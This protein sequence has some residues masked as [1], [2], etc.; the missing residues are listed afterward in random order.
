MSRKTVFF[1]PMHVKSTIFS[2][3][4]EILVHIYRMLSYH[5]R[6]W[7]KKW[8]ERGQKMLE[9]QKYSAGGKQLEMSAYVEKRKDKDERRM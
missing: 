2:E 6:R 1:Y 5:K 4:G 9:V 7:V 8:R 3:I